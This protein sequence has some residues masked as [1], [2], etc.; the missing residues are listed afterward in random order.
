MC[1]SRRAA[2]ARRTSRTLACS[3]L[4]LAMTWV[5]AGPAGAAPAE[6]SP[7]LECAFAKPDGTG[8]VTVWGYDNPTSST[9]N[10]PIGDRNHFDPGAQ[11]QGQPE[12]FAP[13]R[14]D[15][16]VI[17]DV[18]GTSVLKWTSGS[19]TVKADTTPVCAANPVPL[20]GSGLSTV[21]ALLVLAVGAIG[22]NAR[23]YMRRRARQL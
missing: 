1:K 19:T 6:T 16:V 4:V 13:G 7:I 22:L 23:L 20:T 8:Y 9:E 18:D 14:H 5:H 10:Y 15:N 11:D 21:V 12:D 2:V 3:L 17:V